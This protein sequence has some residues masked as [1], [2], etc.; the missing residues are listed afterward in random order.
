MK[1]AF[2]FVLCGLIAVIL[3]GNAV[4]YANDEIRVYLNEERLEFDVLPQ[5]VAGRTIVPVRVILE[6][7]GAEVIWHEDTQKVTARIRNEWATVSI[8]LRID[9]HTMEISTARRGTLYDLGDY[10]FYYHQPPIIVD[11]IVLDIPPRIVGNRTLVPLRAVS[12][13]FGAIVEWDANTR[14]VTLIYA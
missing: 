2:R 1:K 12:E 3:L 14:T 5:I 8:D 11:L 10:G 7:M 9:S 4:V 13:A 6:A